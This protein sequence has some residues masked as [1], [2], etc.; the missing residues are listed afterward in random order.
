MRAAGQR[1]MAARTEGRIGPR[2]RLPSMDRRHHRACRQGTYRD[3]MKRGIA[4]M[5]SITKRRS[6]DP[7]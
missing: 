4:G 2:F 6:W 1:R 3:L 7:H 5:L